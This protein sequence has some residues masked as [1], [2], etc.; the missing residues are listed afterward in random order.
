[1]ES[2]TATLI[3]RY[4]ESRR[5]HPLAEPG[6]SLETAIAREIELLAPIRGSADFILDSSNLTLG[7]LQN[8]LYDFFADAR[9]QHGISVTVESFGFKHGIPMD[10]DLV[11]D[12]RFMPNPYYV[13][14]LRPHTGLEAPVADFVFSHCQ[15]RDFLTRLQEMMDFLLPLYAE[16][17]KLTLTVAI[18]CT[19]G[20]HR[21]VAI[22]SALNTYLR[23][24]GV[25]SVNINRDIEK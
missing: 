9:R 23:T 20:H 8:R 15:A 24:K 4:K 6:E 14:E 13:E 1:M 17:G 21:S 19:G 5:S 25:D 12:V 16:E 2:D 22:A 18:G 7:M 10:A 11:F 3:H